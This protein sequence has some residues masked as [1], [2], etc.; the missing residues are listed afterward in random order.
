M[1]L[2]RSPITKLPALLTGPVFH[3]IEIMPGFGL[4]Q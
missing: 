2:G 4:R 3:E 1:S